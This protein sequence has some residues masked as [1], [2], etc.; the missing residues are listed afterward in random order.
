MVDKIFKMKT[1]IGRVQAEV[2][3]IGILL[4]VCGRNKIKKTLY[5]YC[6]A[7]DNYYLYNS[8]VTNRWNLY[9]QSHIPIV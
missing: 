4:F 8:G 5:D 2:F 3:N 9:I 6:K 1:L 7:T